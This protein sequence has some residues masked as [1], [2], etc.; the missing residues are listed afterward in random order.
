MLERNP[1]RLKEWARKSRVNAKSCIWEITKE[2]R[3]AL[4]ERDKSVLM[5]NKSNMIQQCTAASAV[6]KG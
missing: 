5:D 6:A 1:D 4:L 2:P 3:T